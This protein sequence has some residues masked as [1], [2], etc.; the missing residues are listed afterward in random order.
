M[1]NHSLRSSSGQSE[2][3]IIQRRQAYRGGE[4]RRRP[5]CL[6]RSAGTKER[7]TYVD[8]PT[9]CEEKQG[10]VR[11]ISTQDFSSEKSKTSSRVEESTGGVLTSAG[12]LFEMLQGVMRPFLEED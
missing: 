4:H 8:T 12:T 9:C 6:L 7:T 11:Q 2:I 3:E 5:S 1:T 10:C